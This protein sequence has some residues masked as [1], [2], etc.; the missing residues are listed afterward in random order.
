M[1]RIEFE[2]KKKWIGRFNTE[3]EAARAYDQAARKCHGEYACLNFR[4]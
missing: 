4:E 1:A 3:I 2:G